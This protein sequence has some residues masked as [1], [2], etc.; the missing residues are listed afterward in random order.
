MVVL[1]IVLLLLVVIFVPRPNVRLTNARYQTSPCDPVT[2]TVIATAYVTFTNSGMLDGYIIARFYVD[3]ERRTTS[4]FP[5]A[6][7][8]TVEETLVATIQGC[9]YHRYRL[10]T[11]VPPADSSGPRLSR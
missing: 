6:A 8:L 4:G 1:A 11:C 10:D 2:S 3:G 9:S 5:V 7:Q